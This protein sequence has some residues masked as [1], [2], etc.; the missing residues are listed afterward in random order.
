MN[1]PQS[2]LEQGFRHY[3]A[4]RMK[5]AEDFYRRALKA[6][7]DITVGLHL[8]GIVITAYGLTDVAMQL[9]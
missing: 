9:F 7:P 6:E 2:L 4:G 3:Q 1:N 8:L 5:D